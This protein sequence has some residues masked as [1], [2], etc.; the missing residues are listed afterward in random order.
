MP[1][2][3][4]FSHFVW[5]AACLVALTS[6]GEFSLLLVL[7]LLV[8]REALR[9]E[10]HEIVVTLRMYKELNDLELPP[11]PQTKM[12]DEESFSLYFWLDHVDGT[13]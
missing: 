9:Q 5:D 1:G 8:A 4:C 3:I 11:S 6:C 2:L 7:L 10:S 12:E 13:T